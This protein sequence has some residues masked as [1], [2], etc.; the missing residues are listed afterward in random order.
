LTEKLVKLGIPKSFRDIVIQFVTTGGNIGTAESS[1]AAQ[2]HLKIVKK[3]LKAAAD[4]AGHGIHLSL[5]IGAAIVLL[6]AVIALFAVRRHSG[7]FETAL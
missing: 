7:D 2:G 4:S 3:V 5:E 6:A 1:P